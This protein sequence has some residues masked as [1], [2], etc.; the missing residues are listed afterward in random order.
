MSGEAGSAGRCMQSGHGTNTDT[1]THMHAHTHTC[2]PITT[3]RCTPNLVPPTHIHDM[4]PLP[5]KVHAVQLSLKGVMGM[6]NSSN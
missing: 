3:L 2:A 5:W 6:Q 1:Q 4:D